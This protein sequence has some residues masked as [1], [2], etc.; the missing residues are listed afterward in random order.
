MRGER[1]TCTFNSE[2]F[3]R[4]GLAQLSVSVLET[5]GELTWTG[6]IVWPDGRRSRVFGQARTGSARDVGEESDGADK[7]PRSNPS[8]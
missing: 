1:L 4:D 2:P 5:D 3:E 6:E 8:T 7:N